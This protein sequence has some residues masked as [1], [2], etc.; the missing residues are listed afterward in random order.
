MCGFEKDD[1]SGQGR[2]IGGSGW[3]THIHQSRDPLDPWYSITFENPT[4]TTKSIKGWGSFNDYID[5]LLPDSLKKD[6]GR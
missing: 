1:S 4:E 3:G 5:S 2:I 6:L